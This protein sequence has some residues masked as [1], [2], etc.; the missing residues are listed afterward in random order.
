MD[1][2]IQPNQEIIRQIGGP[3]Y[4][5]YGRKY[6]LNK[7]CLEHKI[8]E[9]T[10]IYNAMTGSLV[11]LRS[12]ERINIFTEDPCD[13]AEFL[14][15]N[16]F[17]VP[18]QFEEKPLVDMIR[19]RKWQPITYNYLDSPRHF[20]ILTTTTCNARCFYC[21]E[22]K[23][24]GKTP[25]SIETAEKVAK[26]II[27]HCPK[28]TEVSL[29]WFGGE[30][31][32]NQDVIDLIISRI[33]SAGYQYRSSMISNGYLMNEETVKKAK[34]FWN[35]SNIQITLDGTEKIYNKVK[36]YIYK[37]N[38][39]PFKTVIDNIHHL[40]NNNILVSVRM[41]CDKHNEED[42]KELVKYL[43]E[44]FKGENNFS[45]YVWPIFEEGFKRS[46]EDHKKLYKTLE[47]IEKL[48]VENGYPLSHNIENDIK[49][50]HCMVDSG[51][52]VLISPNGDLGLCE[53][54]IDSRFFSHIDNSDKKD[55]EEIKTWRNYRPYGDICQNC[56]LYPI[57]LRMKDCPDDFDCDEIV[58]N[59]KIHH[60]QMD[61]ENSYRN[62]LKGN[63]QCQ[64]S[65]C[66]NKHQISLYEKVITHA[67]GTVEHIPVNN[68]DNNQS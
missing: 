68:N 5:V 14:L 19:E 31:L 63:I 61:M 3:Q 1:I 30:P 58:Y 20:T 13:Y 53:H 51:N 62:F 55:F 26:Y 41:N 12:Y 54:Y 37:D 67:D 24:K 64:N 6:R 4:R 56:P 44:E 2:V 47:E 42:L 29:D 23:S 25:M 8:K 66:C 33:S 60:A 18:E 16:Y 10:L 35:L 15:N 9:G 46:S 40:L 39:N 7:Y 32:F 17:I 36:N 11:F 57:C 48:I 49:G 21:Y 34:D 65:A 38:S 43:S 52:G 59:Y 28:G 50:I 45:M 22:L 27:T